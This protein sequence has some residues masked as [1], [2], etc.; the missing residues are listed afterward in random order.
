MF[1]FYLILFLFFIW[2][3]FFLP[4]QVHISYL[5]NKKANRLQV[6]VKFLFIKI[7]KD[8]SEPLLKI[9]SIMS[10]RRFSP[11][12]VKESLHAQ[13]L[14]LRNYNLIFKRIFVWW[15]KFIQ[16][17]SHGIRMT[18]KILKP[19]R[20][21]KLHVYTE[22][23]LDDAAQTGIAVG[24]VWAIISFGLSQISK[25]IVLKPETPQIKVVPIF[26]NPRFYLEYDCI[27]V[28]PLGHIIIVF[29]QMVRFMRFS[30]NMIKTNSTF[31]I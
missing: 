21:Q 23:G 16:I 9:L 4:I 12:N 29:I 6:Q 15:P 5:R 25:W 27:I 17:I 13:R 30:T 20:C 22:I 18:G 8:I 28:F 11:E 24:S 19:I 1:L 26:N 31:F 3:L 2:I 14:P 10:K 7:R